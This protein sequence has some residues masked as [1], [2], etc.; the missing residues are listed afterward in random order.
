MLRPAIQR[1]VVVA[2]AELEQ[3]GAVL[4]AALE[5]PGVGDPLAVPDGILIVAASGLNGYGSGGVCPPI[6]PHNIG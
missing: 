1:R 4:V 3:T 2:R 6:I 5:L